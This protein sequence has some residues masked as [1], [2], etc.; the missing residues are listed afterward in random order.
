VPPPHTDPPSLTFERILW[1]WGYRLPAGVDEAGRGAWAGPVSAAAVILPA[2]ERIQQTLSGVRDSKQ[3]TPRERD[4]WA[5]VIRKT[6][7]AWAV[8]VASS[9]EIDTLGILPATRL[10]MK[11]AV[12][13]LS[14]TPDHLLIDALRLPALGI[15]QTALI[16]GD[17]LVLSIAAAS[18]LA[19]TH[20]DGLMV[21]LE[22]EFP[23]YGFTRHKG[24]GTR[25]HQQSLAEHGPC[26]EHRFSFAPVKAAAEA[27]L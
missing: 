4:Q 27:R 8:A 20:R 5:G 24:Y 11:R 18:V 21:K 19:K 25:L 16:K 22:G 9:S 3:M 1:D 23:S 10:A 6:S 2:D 7:I 17:T 14:L 15:P 13:A 26:P 12:E